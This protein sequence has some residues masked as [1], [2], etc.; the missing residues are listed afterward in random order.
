MRKSVEHFG[1]QHELV[2]IRFGARGLLR[3]CPDFEMRRFEFMKDFL[4]AHGTHKKAGPPP[5][6]YPIA[7]LP[8]RCY[9]NAMAVSRDFGLI[10]CEGVMLLPV[11]E[12]MFPLPH[13]WCEDKAGN[14]IDPTAGAAQNESGV[15]YVGVRFKADYAWGWWLRYGFHGM[16]DG[17]PILGDSVGV[18]VDPK[19][20]WSFDCN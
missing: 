10:Y 5:P 7:E 15:A 8:G 19:T 4:K 11:G 1:P 18:Y 3:V 2:N 17:H 20:A 6:G 16:L 12:H 9:D 13:G 14:I